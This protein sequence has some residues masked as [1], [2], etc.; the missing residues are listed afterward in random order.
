[1]YTILVITLL[2]LLVNDI[3]ATSLRERSLLSCPSYGYADMSCCITRCNEDC[4]WSTYRTECYL[5]TS[6][7]DCEAPPVTG[8]P[9]TTLAP[10]YPNRY[11]AASVRSSYYSDYTTSVAA[12]ILVPLAIMI[13]VMILGA[14]LTLYCCI[15][16][17]LRKTEAHLAPAERIVDKNKCNA[18]WWSVC[19]C[20]IGNLVAYCKISEKIKQNNTRFHNK[21][22]PPT[23]Q[24]M[25]YVDSFGTGGSPG[26]LP[27]RPTNAVPVEFVLRNAE[28]LSGN[29]CPPRPVNSSLPASS[30]PPRPGSSPGS[31]PPRPTN[32]V[33]VAYIHQTGESLSSNASPPRPGNS[34]PPRPTN[35]SLSSNPSPP[36][37]GSSTLPR[38]GTAY[39]T[40]SGDSIVLS[41]I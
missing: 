25:Q 35:A 39:V 24:T 5:H 33:P 37:P 16:P 22:T 9:T 19:L 1:M 17:C 41:N 28:S 10:G 14:L 3:Y 18:I 2:A 11:P 34:T 13:P 32:V 31:L 36:R 29:A 26:S 40:P 21:S 38:P 23:V 6:W 27:P 12:V 15:L 20:G 7:C 4:S 8:K 30:I